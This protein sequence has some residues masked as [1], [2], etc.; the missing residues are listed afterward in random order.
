MSVCHKFLSDKID[1]NKADNT[2]IG[3][4]LTSQR[5]NLTFEVKGNHDKK[6]LIWQKSGQSS[7]GQE[8]AYLPKRMQK[9]IFWICITAS[10]LW[11]FQIFNLTSEVKFDLGGQKSSR[12]KIT[13]LTKGLCIKEIILISNIIS[14]L[15]TFEILSLASEVKG[16]NVNLLGYVRR[17]NIQNKDW[18]TLSEVITL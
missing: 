6:L 1:F 16:H 18:S 7:C 14:K 17:V 11:T 9:K 5:S 12:Q 13:Y 15:W 8:N 10:E 2:A 3:A 4:K